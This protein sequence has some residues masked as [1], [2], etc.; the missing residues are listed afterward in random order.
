M[1]TYKDVKGVR[2]KPGRPANCC[3]MSALPWLSFTGMAH[4]QATEPPFLPPIITFGKYFAQGPDMLLPIAVSVH[5]AAADGSH[6]SKLINDMQA[7][8]ASA[9]QWMRP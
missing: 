2:A 8:A 1:E 4:V 5:H 9:G 7:L 3:P 6:T